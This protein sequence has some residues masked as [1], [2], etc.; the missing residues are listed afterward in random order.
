MRQQQKHVELVALHLHKWQHFWPRTPT[1]Y[2]EIVG[3]CS[4]EVKKLAS[5]ILGL[6]GEGLGLKS[7]YFDDELSERIIMTGLPEPSLTLGT[8]EHVEA[9]VE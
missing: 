9:E 2:Q 6:I 7:E 1:R 5:R 3:A 8:S 4:V